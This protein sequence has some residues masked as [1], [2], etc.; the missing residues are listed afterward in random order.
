MPKP[1]PPTLRASDPTGDLVR[2]ML[3]SFEDLGNNPMA[4]I[5]ARI[6]WRH[7]QRWARRLGLLPKKS[8]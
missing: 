7:Y 1:P 6:C 4:R 8:A 5:D 3:T 2:A